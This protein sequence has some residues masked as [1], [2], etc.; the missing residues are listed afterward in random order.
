MRLNCRSPAPGRVCSLPPAPCCSLPA[1]RSCCWLVGAAPPGSKVYGSPSVKAAW[2]GRWSLAGLV[3]R[4]VF[5]PVPNVDSILVSFERGELPGTE[6]ERIATFALV[7]GAF[8]Q[9]RKTLRNA[10]QGVATSEMIEAAGLRPDARAEQIDVAGFVRL[11]NLVP[12]A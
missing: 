9:R 4:Q 5:W 11:A 1:A 10:L 6:Q 3:S 2:Y 7:D 12:S 8:G